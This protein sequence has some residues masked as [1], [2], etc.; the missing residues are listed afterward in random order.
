M[1]LFVDFF[2]SG[3]HHF[4]AEFGDVSFGVVGEAEAQEFVFG[5][6]D[7]IHGCDFIFYLGIAEYEGLVA[8]ASGCGE[9]FFVEFGQ[10]GDAAFV[11]GAPVGVV[12]D[13]PVAVAVIGVAAA[14]RKGFEAVFAYGFPVFSFYAVAEEAVAFFIVSEVIQGHEGSV[15]VF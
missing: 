9:P 11:Y 6:E 8:A 7:F 12:A 15:G 10:V 13:S 14:V 1:D 5:V 4:I 2:C 3:G